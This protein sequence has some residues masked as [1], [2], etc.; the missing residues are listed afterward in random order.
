MSYG[1]PCLV[2]DYGI[3]RYVL[4]QEGYFADFTTPGRLTQLIEEVLR[5]D[6]NFEAQSKRH[7]AVFERFAWDHLRLFYIEMIQRCAS[8]VA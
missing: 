5:E 4:G 8:E 3:T 2:H 7:R 6:H 1:L